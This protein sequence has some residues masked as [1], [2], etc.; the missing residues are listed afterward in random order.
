MIETAIQTA[1]REA[2]QRELP[3]ALAEALDTNKPSHP[4]LATREQCARALNISTRSLDTLRSQG[5]PTLMVLESPRFELAE[6]VAWLRERGR[7]H[8]A[9]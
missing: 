1:V 6:V 9:G 7:N 3:A 5:L 2:L 8:D 4:Q